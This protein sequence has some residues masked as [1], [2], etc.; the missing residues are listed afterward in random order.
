[1]TI[2]FDLFKKKKKT[3]MQIAAEEYALKKAEQDKA[4]FLEEQAF[5]K[6]YGKGVRAEG[7]KGEILQEPTKMSP[8]DKKMIKFL[9]SQGQ[10]DE[11]IGS[12]LAGRADMQ[13]KIKV[14]LG[15]EK[16]AFE[17]GRAE[18]SKKFGQETKRMQADLVK[19]GKSPEDIKKFQESRQQQYHTQLDA[20]Q[21]RF[22]AG[23]TAIKSGSAAGTGAAAQ[24]FAQEGTKQAATKGTTAGT[25]AG[26]GAGAGGMSA[27]ASTGVGVA[28]SMG[29]EM[30]GGAVDEGGTTTDTG[31]GVGGGMLKG[32]GSGAAM[33]AMTGT[34]VGIAVG[35]AV[36]AVVGG[37]SGGLAAKSRRK[38]AERKA[39]A[40]AYGDMHDSLARIEQN[41]AAQINNALQNMQQG[42]QQSLLRKL[43]VNL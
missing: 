36:G 20:Q 7:F 17:R 14:R 31:S 24:Y 1:M 16:E 38:A 5:E 13:N 4:R 43:K 25:T 21:Q 27:G 19:A 42:F 2:S 23:N 28:A 22:D 9:Q 6:E 40:E 41:K 35:A 30:A 32:A 15:K 39:R 37:I 26:A 8:E 34:P 18:F 12:Q 3:P 33:G 11:E 29:G 10:S